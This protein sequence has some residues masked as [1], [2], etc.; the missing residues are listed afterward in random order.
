MRLWNGFS[1]IDRGIMNSRRGIKR[2]VSHQTL[3]SF[4]SLAACSVVLFA[5][6]CLLAESSSK[7]AL[8]DPPL[9]LPKVPAPE[10]NPVTEGKVH[11]GKMLFFD[12][13]LSKDSTVSCASCHDPEKGYSN[14]EAVATGVGGAKGGRNSPTIVN[15]AY[16]K[17]MFWDGRAGSLEEQALGP[18]QNPI[19]MTMT[20]TDVESRLAAIDGYRS[21]FKKVF[22]DEKITSDR[23]AAAIAS[24]ER[25]IVSGN[26]PYDRYVNGDKSAM[27]ESARRGKN[28]FFGKANCGACHAGSS[29]MDNAFHNIGVGMSADKPDV[30]RK[31]ISKL[32][33]DNGAFKTP[34][35]R[36]IDRTAPYMHDGSQATLE[37]VVEHYNKGGIP[38]EWLDEEIFPLH[39]TPEE[40]ADLV[41]FMKEGLASDSFPAHKPPQLP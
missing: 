33:G 34:T 24:F 20:L 25:T 28:L 32:D 12:T 29:F 39:L 15:S 41:T 1:R 6:A 21:E 4:C 3:K 5:A 11:L 36:D 22:G 18:I 38:N 30:G 13:R 7:T 35:L 9:G 17:L 23:I 40:K 19:E 2:T 14:N 8:N 31:A 16:S 10:N 26:A 37:E 27:S